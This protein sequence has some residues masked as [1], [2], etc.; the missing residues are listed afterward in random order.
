MST[1]ADGAETS[2][3]TSP[4]MVL[5]GEDPVDAESLKQL[6]EDAK[7]MAIE[8]PAQL[9]SI[10]NR[11]DELQT[12]L[13]ETL[14]TAVVLA[15]GYFGLTRETEDPNFVAHQGDRSKE[16]TDNFET[17]AAAYTQEKVRINQIIAER[18]AVLDRTN[19]AVQRLRARFPQLNQ[20][21]APRPTGGPTAEPTA[22]VPPGAAGHQDGQSTDQT[23]PVL[24][25]LPVPQPIGILAPALHGQYEIPLYQG[26]DSIGP[27][28]CWMDPKMRHNAYLALSRDAP[29]FHHKDEPWSNFWCKFKNL[30][31]DHV[32][33]SVAQQ[34]RV[35]FRALRGN[36][37]RLAYP[38]YEPADDN[39][40]SLEAYG[41]RLEELFEPQAESEQ[42]KINF[43]ARTQQTGE[44]PTAY[45]QAKRAMFE[46]AFKPATRDYRAFYNAVIAGLLNQEMRYQL[47]WRMPTPIEDMNAFLRTIQE[48]ATIVRQQLTEGEINASA[49]LGAEAFSSGYNYHMTPTTS[50]GTAATGTINMVNRQQPKKKQ[51][52]GACYHCQGTDHYVSQCPRKA[53]GLPAVQAVPTAAVQPVY[54]AQTPARGTQTRGRGRGQGRGGRGRGGA[55][56]GPRP[57]G[58]NR[59]FQ[60]KGRFGRIA[61]IYENDDGEAT[62]EEVDPACQEFKAT[63]PGV[64]QVAAAV[65]EEATQEYD[66]P[67]HFLG[68]GH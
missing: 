50:T 35:V 52:K 12:A 49:A 10:P 23:A 58:N 4:R 14:E 54:G 3:P 31:K 27:D 44:H 41:A 39:V 33:T 65:P 25:G 63:T 11:L 68:L 6:A 67:K 13:D 7:N 53:A 57:G 46:K 45:Y 26:S 28:G 21:P 47:R 38:Q 2:A 9:R 55:R 30:L 37:C 5:T 43:Y 22:P 24:T 20:Q 16:A 17:A 34:K 48:A 1:A 29:Q 66:L 40:E 62:W 19:G 18:R 32:G 51:Q 59:L 61:F 60:Q 36:A 8:D 64:N 42:M 15:T 56:G